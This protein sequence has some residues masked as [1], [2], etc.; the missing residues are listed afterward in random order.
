MT[1][2]GGIPAV[3]YA[4][5]SSNSSAGIESSTSISYSPTTTNHVV[6]SLST[7]ISTMSSD[8]STLPTTSATGAAFMSSNAFIP[9]LI[10]SGLVGI[11]FIGACIICCWLV[12][13]RRT[14]R[15]SARDN[16]SQPTDL[17]ASNLTTEEVAEV[18]PFPANLASRPGRTCTS[19][20]RTDRESTAAW[21]DDSEFDMLATDGSTI[22]RTLSSTSTRRQS[23][24]SSSGEQDDTPGSNSHSNPFAHPGYTLPPRATPKLYTD[25]KSFMNQTAMS[26]GSSSG[27]RSTPP[28][29]CA[30]TSSS[31]LLTPL[32]AT[33]DR[34][35][36]NNP[37]RDPP[38]VSPISPFNSYPSGRLQTSSRSPPVSDRSWSTADDSAF[39]RQAS[40][41]NP[42]VRPFAGITI[43][44]HIDGGRTPSRP[45]TG[46][47]VVN[48]D[49]TDVVDERGRVH[50]PPTYGEL[51]GPG[52]DGA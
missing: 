43:V 20:D 16:R 45:L 23:L 28:W 13:R 41:H 47:G 10:V 7:P 14:R 50:L 40:T 9:V 33:Y 2:T 19:S 24:R 5:A 39:T 15:R 27:S 30:S 21:T 26:P 35:I 51:Y 6:S 12:R 25:V 34:S 32:S 17:F 46:Q 42:S 48:A 31:Q 1:S 37:F 3:T 11:G 38:S 36:P 49:G 52:G 8:N 4:V 29:T 44:Q 22:T 18:V